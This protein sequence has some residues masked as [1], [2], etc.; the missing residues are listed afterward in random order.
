MLGV[1]ASVWWLTREPLKSFRHEPTGITG[2]YP[3]DLEAKETSQQDREDNFFL[4]LEGSKGINED[5]LVRMSY[6]EGLRTAT[7]L[8]KTKLIPLVMSDAEKSLPVTF[9]DI[10]VDLRRQFAVNGHEAGEIIFTYKGKT[11][12]SVKRRLVMLSKDDDTVIYIAAETTQ[13]EYSKVNAKYFDVLI[14]TL[15]FE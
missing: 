6:S 10:Q 14:E 1:S 15:R 2:M 12:E 3:A 9:G 5:I 11:G 13:A 4:R 8:T 7:T